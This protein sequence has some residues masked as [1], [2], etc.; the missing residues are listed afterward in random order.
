MPRIL[1][2]QE[3]PFSTDIM[4]CDSSVSCNSDLSCYSQ[5]SQPTHAFGEDS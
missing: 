5:R 2:L 4:F 1:S 3:L